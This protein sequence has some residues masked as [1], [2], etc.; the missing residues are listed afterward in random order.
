MT[1]AIEASSAER[2]RPGHRCTPSA[3]LSLHML[4]FAPSRGVSMSNIEQS[5]NEFESL[6]A[7]QENWP[8]RKSMADNLEERVRAGEIALTRRQFLAFRGNRDRKLARMLAYMLIR[9]DKAPSD[10]SSLQELR[11]SI[12]KECEW[13]RGARFAPGTSTMPLQYAL[14]AFLDL[15]KRDPASLAAAAS[16]DPLFEQIYREMTESGRDP[17]THVRKKI[18]QIRKLLQKSSDPASSPAVEAARIA[19]QGGISQSKMAFR[20]GIIVAII[21]GVVS[22]CAAL[23]HDWDKLPWKRPAHPAPSAVPASLPPK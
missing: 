23:I 2:T 11:A 20:L 22:L 3:R 7:T 8:L 13:L 21:T 19:S 15:I 14:S 12:D 16:D 18:E 4:Y 9:Y 10:V 17:G 5:C 6:P 1:T